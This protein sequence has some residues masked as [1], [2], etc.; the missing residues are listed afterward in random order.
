MKA[1]LL[2]RN[3]DA[4]LAAFCC[5]PEGAPGWQ[6]EVETFLRTA[7]F[8]RADYVVGLWDG[9]QLVGVSGFNPITIKGLP[10]ASPI[11]LPGW[12]LIVI[13]VSLDQQQNGHGK[14][15][16]AETL[17]IMAQTD[18]TRTLVSARAH[19]EN[20]VSIYVCAEAGIEALPPPD[21]D[22]IRL[23]GGVPGTAVPNWL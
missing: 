4:E 9:G 8:R 7:V 21:G 13:G 18:P 10:V 23:I 19:R 22:Y 20:H 14:T 5:C 11:D 6:Q 15:I 1:S 2:G 16:L 3:H 12:D 17:K